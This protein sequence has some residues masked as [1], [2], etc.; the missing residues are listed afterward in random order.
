MK[1][2]AF[3]LLLAWAATAVAEDGPSPVDMRLAEAGDA[4]AASRLGHYYIGPN[5][6][7]TEAAR[8]FRLAADSG[9]PVAQFQLA[10]LLEMGWGVERN[11]VEAARLYRLAA[12]SGVAPAQ[13]FLGIFFVVGRGVEKDFEQAAYWFR[14]AADQGN[15][16]SQS[17][18]GVLY[19]DGLGVT[20]DPSMAL[21]LFGQ[22]ADQGDAS[23]L[24]RMGVSR[25]EG[26]GGVHDLVEAYMYY[27][28]AFERS[29]SLDYEKA[30]DRVA[31]ELS[32]IDLNRALDL[33][34]TW[35]A[36]HKGKLPARR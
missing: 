18:L 2:C 25:E 35:K 29:N 21:Q 12:E 23:G 17:H 11:D 3:L 34:V 36:N 26:L 30:R 13:C 4:S 27:Q 6:N 28:L 31:S 15:A 10:T 16:P 7:F 1:R 32:P 9:L 5:R 20:Q 19:A 14:K 22:A 33:I 8:W 24:Y